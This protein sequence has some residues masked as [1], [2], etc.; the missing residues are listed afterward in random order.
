MQRSC[1]QRSC[2]QRSWHTPFILL[3]SKN[4]SID[5]HG[6]IFSLVP[7]SFNTIKLMTLIII[8]F[9][10]YIIKQFTYYPITVIGNTIY[11]H[12]ISSSLSRF[13]I[14]YIF[15]RSSNRTPYYITKDLREIPFEGLTYHHFLN[16]TL[17]PL[18]PHSPNEL[19]SLSTHTNLPHLD[20]LQDTILSSFPSLNSLPISSLD[21]FVSSS[22][23]ENVNPIISIKRFCNNMYYIITTKEIWLTRLIFTDSVTPLESNDII[24]GLHATI[25]SSSKN[26]IYSIVRSLDTITISDPEI[27]TVMSRD[28]LFNVDSNREIIPLNSEHS[29]E[30]FIYNLKIPRNYI[31]N[32]FY[33]IHPFHFPQTWD[34]FLTI[35]LLTLATVYKNIRII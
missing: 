6:T 4:L 32:T 31:Q 10:S 28:L 19:L 1:D 21:H 15:S 22:I 2:D 33:V 16:N 8:A 30:C 24:S 11:S 25:S 9:M 5:I 17:Y 3:H 18:I 12:V 14:P 27:T 29:Y 35:M 13:H 20:I 34:P 26:S 7:H 23:R